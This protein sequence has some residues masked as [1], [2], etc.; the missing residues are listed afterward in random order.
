[1]SVT[2][3]DFEKYTFPLLWSLQKQH[4]NH[5]SYTCGANSEQKLANP[6]SLKIKVYQTHTISS[7]DL[8]FSLTHIH[9]WNT[10]ILRQIPGAVFAN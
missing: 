1:M 10:R 7:I 9:T 6:H 5:V 3:V 4:N 8:F 2:Q